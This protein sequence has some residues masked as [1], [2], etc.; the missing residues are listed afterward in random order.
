MMDTRVKTLRALL[1][2]VTDPE[3]PALSIDEMGILRDVSMEGETVMVTITPTYSGC[4][5]IDQITEDVQRKLNE[6]GY[7]KSR[8]KLVLTPAWTTDWMTDESREKLRT[9]GISPPCRTTDIN[10][11]SEEHR[12]SFAAPCPQCQSVNTK[13]LSEFGST[14]CKALWKCHDCM[15]PFDYFKPL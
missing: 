4:P 11:S 12:L 3:I 9:Y 2:S 1:A 7:R 8:V 5:A 15:E 13:Q 14:A 10:E 6:H